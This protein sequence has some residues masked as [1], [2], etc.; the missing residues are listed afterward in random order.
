MT[1]GL[2]LG[3]DHLADVQLLGSGGFSVVYAARHTL[4]DRRVA[5]KVLTNVKSETDRRR[6][7]RE[8]QVMGR[9]SGA[10][11]VVTVFHAAYSDQGQPYLIMELVEGGTL[12]DRVAA[13]G[14]LGWEEAVDLLIPTAAA[15]GY[16]HDE[17]VLHRDI[18]PENI[19]LDE[20]EPKLTDFGIAQLRDSTGT[21]STNIAASWLHAPPET[22]ENE[23]DERSDLYSLASTAHT[24]I[25]GRPPFWREDDQSL[26]PLVNRLLNEPPPELPDHLAPPAL[27]AF[28]VRAMAKD[29]A[30]RPQTAAAFA[31][32]LASIRGLGA[33][34]PHLTEADR[35]PE[36]TRHVGGL[37]APP[38][39]FDRNPTTVDTPIVT[40]TSTADTVAMTPVAR[41]DADP[42]GTAG[43][44]AISAASPSS[45]PATSA[46][47]SASAGVPPTGPPPDG[48]SVVPGAHVPSGA[49]GAVLGQHPGTSGR[50]PNDTGRPVTGDYR[51]TGHESK[52]RFGI[53]GALLL[54]VLL[55][56][57]A[58]FA[59]WSTLP[60]GG[61]AADSE[62]ATDDDPVVEIPSLIGLTEADAADVLAAADIELGEVTRQ[63]SATADEGI[64][65]G[66]TPPAG[67]EADRVDLVVSSGPDDTD[68]GEGL[69]VVADVV[70][71]EETEAIDR[72]EA[73]GIIVSISG[74]EPSAAVAEGRVVSQDPAGGTEASLVR[75][76]VSTGDDDD[77]PVLPTV[78]DVRGLSES[79]AVD[80]LESLG[81]EVTIGAG[82]ESEEVDADH[83][84]AQSPAAGTQADAVTLT[85][86]TGGP[87][88]VTIDQVAFNPGSPGTLDAGER[89]G[90]SIDYTSTHD[91]PIRIWARPA[92]AS[93]E[94]FSPSPAIEPGSGTH[95][96]W[97]LLS[98]A[99]T[100]DR[101]RVFAIDDESK[102]LLAERFFDV[103]YTWQNVPLAAPVQV[104]PADGSVF[105]FFPRTTTLQWNAVDRAESYS[106]EIQFF[107]SGTWTTHGTSTGG[108]AGTSY[109]FDFVGAQPGRWRVWAVDE[110]GEAG[111]RS[112]WWG[113]E[114]LR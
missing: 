78:P 105:D 46:W 38:P 43:A 11:N 85:I 21:A 48:R 10:P 67:G 64:V 29:Q 73:L 114:Y 113:F 4:F 2:G 110:S 36:L 31:E 96:A 92:V 76:V 72:L 50:W 107:S 32:E 97:F 59:W 22:F 94:L 74:R 28:L 102:E 20:G 54:V 35:D 5:V 19:L 40:G 100:I 81:I 60:D 101:V 3:I 65:T 42:T 99:G 18:K 79:A 58:A 91:G 41:A 84:I 13:Q 82:Q 24:V 71:L 70:G 53:I 51:S 57:G 14:P 108:I 39:G 87:G 45:T 75:L 8:C 109:T 90:V 61:A 47:P 17:G 52:R 77:G 16:A 95:A 25:A 89:L 112:G 1:D 49:P 44:P 7:E 34:T 6:F 86:S 88:G 69:P 111:S 55:G 66:Q 12:A 63:P 62:V 27:R 37:L 68:D 83:V 15:L 104:A 56:G 80:L 106:V 98:E 30:A 93:D 103:D 33:P 26:H 9:L 23:R